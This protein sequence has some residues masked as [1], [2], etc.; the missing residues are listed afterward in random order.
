[1]HREYVWLYSSGLLIRQRCTAP[2]NSAPYRFDVV[3]LTMSTARHRPLGE[4][5][6]VMTPL[7]AEM[8]TI[9]DLVAP[10]RAAAIDLT[11]FVSSYNESEFIIA[12]LDA[13]RET[14]RKV[15]KLTYEMIVID[16]VSKDN[17]AD[18]VEAYIREHPDDRIIL[19]RNAVNRGLAQNYV[20][21]AFL[22]KGKYYRLICGDNA[23]PEDTMLA[24]FSAIGEADMLIPYYVSFE[25][26]S[27]LRRTLSNLYAAVINFVSG[28]RLHYY[29]GLAVHLRHN[30]MRWHPN[31]RGFGFQA[32]IIC[33]LA[34][35]GF[36]MKEIPVRTVEM[37][38]GGSA[39]LTW[40][41]FLSVAHT[42]MDIVVRRLA[43]A[44]YRPV[45]RAYK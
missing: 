2:H 6:I 29:N 4:D 45:S 5:R 25:G 33:M 26:K 23:E 1:M 22:G 9:D 8:H 3:Q 42:I 24:V 32:D 36:T 39:A 41:N 30:I 11:I 20:D 13:I 18:L 38:K 34:E 7:A 35:Q 16:D 15:R 27:W 40:K 10:G 28:L 43:N 17:S 12:T 14:L 21:G 37:K 44:V 19:R 31:T